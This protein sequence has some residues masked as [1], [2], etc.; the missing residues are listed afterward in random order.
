MNYLLVMMQ[1]ILLY[2]L[3]FTMT[4]T[5]NVKAKL[6]ALMMKIIILT[7]SSCFFVQLFFFCSFVSQLRPRVTCLMCVSIYNPCIQKIINTDRRNYMFVC[8]LG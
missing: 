1:A 2:R 5:P 4:H 7:F 8:T 3:D 6:R